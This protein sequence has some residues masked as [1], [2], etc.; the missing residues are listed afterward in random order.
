[1][2]RLWPQQF[3]TPEPSHNKSTA[4]RNGIGDAAPLPMTPVVPDHHMIR[5]GLDVGEGLG[6]Q[7][8]ERAEQRSRSAS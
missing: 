7:A 3:P 6:G 8:G 2:K 5:L 4:G 1:M